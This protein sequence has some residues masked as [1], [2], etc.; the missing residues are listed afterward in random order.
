MYSYTLL[1]HKC[2][3][4]FSAIVI[5]VCNSVSTVFFNR[6]FETSYLARDERLP[7]AVWLPLVSDFDLE[8]AFNR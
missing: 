1:A 8:L 2:H 5:L 3:F 7:E 4:H 6:E